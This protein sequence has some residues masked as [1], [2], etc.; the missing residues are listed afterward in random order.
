[1]RRPRTGAIRI[2]ETDGANGSR[3]GGRNG[4]TK[5]AG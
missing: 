2:I 4:R 1:V 3:G 5:K